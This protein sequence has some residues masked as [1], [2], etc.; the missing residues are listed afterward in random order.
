MPYHGSGTTPTNDR[1]GWNGGRLSQ[2]RIACGESTMKHVSVRVRPMFMPPEKLIP[3]ASRACPVRSNPS[4]ADFA[5]AEL[6]SS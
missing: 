2:K 4:Y 3:C 5:L 6:D 1:F